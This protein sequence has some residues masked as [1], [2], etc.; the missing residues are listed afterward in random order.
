[1]VKFII[2][3]KK[4]VNGE[5]ALNIPHTNNNKS[6]MRKNE[7]DDGLLVVFLFLFFCGWVPIY[8]LNIVGK[9][10]SNIFVNIYI[11]CQV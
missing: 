9:K 7:G 3:A 6:R 5:Y 1:M 4:N 10:T 8:C 2:K 11:S